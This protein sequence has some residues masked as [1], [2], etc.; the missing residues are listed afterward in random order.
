MDDEPLPEFTSAVNNKV[1][2]TE[3]QQPD[4][5]ELTDVEYKAEVKRLQMQSNLIDIR[6]AVSCC[7]FISK[8]ATHHVT[9][10]QALVCLSASERLRP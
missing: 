5:E 4:A 6:K 9:A 7:L 2:D 1:S 3:Q 8:H 10:T